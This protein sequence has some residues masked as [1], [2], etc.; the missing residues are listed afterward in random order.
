MYFAT[1]FFLFEVL[2]LSVPEASIYLVPFKI[3]MRFFQVIK[4]TPETGWR[5]PLQG[6][7][8]QNNFKKGELMFVEK[9]I[10]VYDLWHIRKTDST[11][12][13]QSILLEGEMRIA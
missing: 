8:K 10:P 7:I 11:E 5:K 4:F 1:L 12:G 9:E 2:P 3:Q 13:E 6:M